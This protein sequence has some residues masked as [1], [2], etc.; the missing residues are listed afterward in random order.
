MFMKLGYMDQATSI[1]TRYSGNVAS[2]P[3]R[4]KEWEIVRILAKNFHTKPVI[5][6]RLEVEI[7][8]ILKDLVISR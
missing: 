7:N 6:S 8:P 3:R 1:Q 5:D 2:L 4:S